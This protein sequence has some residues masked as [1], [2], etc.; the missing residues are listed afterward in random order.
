MNRPG[1]LGARTYRRHADEVIRWTPLLGR[2]MLVV[3]WENVLEYVAGA[4]ND[5]PGGQGVVGS[6]PAVPTL[7]KASSA[8]LF[9]WPR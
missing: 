4:F 2:F 9:C 3:T 1:R 5:P 6:N 8:G 7:Q